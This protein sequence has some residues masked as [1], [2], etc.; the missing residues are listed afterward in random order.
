[1]EATP[2]PSRMHVARRAAIVL[3]ILAA[4]VTGAVSAYG[5][6]AG[7][8][9]TGGPLSS[10]TAPMDAAVETGL[11][12][13]CEADVAACAA[14]RRLATDLPYPWAMLGYELVVAEPIDDW[15]HGA[16]AAPERTIT[17]YADTDTD[18]NLMA[19]TFA[20]E[21]AHAI[22]QRCDEPVLDAWIRRRGLP[23]DTPHH[24]R[25][26]H[27]FDSAAEDYA[28]AFA[29]YLGYATSRSTLGEPVTQDWLQRNADIFSPEV[30][31][32]V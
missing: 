32:R 3:A 24:A 22:H 13:R 2:S 26:P 14:A 15:H 18:P 7:S 20:H 16:T 29:Q 6:T 4:F 17:L 10:E 31:G 9:A 30:C 27:D 23:A 5:V 8:D 11:P 1:M 21:V 25:P 19:A 12:I 28:D